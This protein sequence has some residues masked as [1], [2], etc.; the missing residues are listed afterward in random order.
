MTPRER[1]T[2]GAAMLGSAIVFLDGTFVNIALQRIGAELPT[3]LLLAPTGF[4][5]LPA[6]IWAATSE[7]RFAQVAA[8]AL[9]LVL[10]SALSLMVM[11]RQ[12]RS[13]AEPR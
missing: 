5:T 2:L 13:T 12:E 4:D 11:L 10:V 3:T 1:G 7:A 6:D 9:F 8:P